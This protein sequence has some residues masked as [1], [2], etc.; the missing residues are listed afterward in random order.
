MSMNPFDEI[1][2]EEALRIKEKGLAQEVVAVTM[3]PSGNSQTLLTALAMGAD[4]G[5]HIETDVELEPIAGTTS[6]FTLE[7][8]FSDSYRI[9]EI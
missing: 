6:E 7:P 8:Y 9:C 3:G 4:R 5:I 1:A 2:I